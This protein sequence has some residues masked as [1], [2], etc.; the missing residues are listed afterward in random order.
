MQVTKYFHGLPKESQNIIYSYGNERILGE[1]IK[2]IQNNI[3]RS[4]IFDLNGK[5]IIL[6]KLLSKGKGDNDIHALLDLNDSPYFPT[7]FA[8]KTR[9][10]LFI[11]KA[12]GRPL[13]EILKKGICLT[14]LKIILG[15]LVKA[16]RAMMD[17]NRYD[18]D[19]KLEHI[20]WDKE[21]KKV[22]WI[23]LGIC[24]KTPKKYSEEEKEKRIQ[25][26]ITKIKINFLI[27][28]YD[29]F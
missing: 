15:H 2:I 20:F 28:G 21:N 14:E 1:S 13:P 9:D 27:N 7:I 5:D 26:C 24:M 10:F 11:E 8:Y 23:D 19:F 6:K 22:T 25:Q 16:K 3:K 4:I 12:K 29:L 18:Y 17:V